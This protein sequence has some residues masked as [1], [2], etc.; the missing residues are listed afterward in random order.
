MDIAKTVAIVTGGASGLGEA[1]VRMFVG[2]GGRAVILD[3]P[4]SPGE[5][6]ASELGIP[7]VSGLPAGHIED[8]A[9]LPFGRRVSLDATRGGPLEWPGAGRAPTGCVRSAAP[10]RR[11]R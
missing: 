9:E 2:A 6:L 11:V 10:A 4:G 1:T 8:N 7:V 3:R 5:G